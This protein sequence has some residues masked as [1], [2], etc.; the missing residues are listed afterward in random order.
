[1]GC[2]G[3]S[4]N[5]TNAITT[6]IFSKTL[7]CICIHYQN[8]HPN[9]AVQE[10]GGRVHS[11]P[12][13]PWVKVWVKNTLGGRGLRGELIFPYTVMM[14]L[15]Q[16]PMLVNCNFQITIILYL[17]ISDIPKKGDDIKG[18]FMTFLSCVFAI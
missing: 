6:K 1:M 13:P 12:P 8:F 17:L 15:C 7:R 2:H 18:K 4:V 10:L 16:M 3:I 14:Y 11:T 5:S 9:A